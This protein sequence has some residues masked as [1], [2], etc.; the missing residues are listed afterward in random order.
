MRAPTIKTRTFLAN[1]P[2][3]QGLSS[4]ELDRI[5]EGTTEVRVT[6]G[7]TIFQRGDP[8][9]GFHALIYGQVKLAFVSPQGTEKVIDILG[10]GQSF[11]E[12]LMFS[13]RSYV[14]YGQALADSLL[15][16]ISKDVIDTE[17]ASDPHLARVMLASLSRRLVGLIQ[18]VE[19]YSLRSGMQRVIGYLLRDVDEHAEQPEGEPVRITL[20][21]NKG[22]IASRLNLTPEHFSRILGELSH[23][24]AIAVRGAEITILDPGR[25]R[26][27]LC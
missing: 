3:F 5:A 6:K 14:V 13:D 10:P 11:G 26:S 23:E 24:G 18:D 16:H 8:C 25:L 20:D 7:Q 1:L 19:A 27:Q 21:A 2:M 9:V 17:I 4:A 12:A 15:L 22:V